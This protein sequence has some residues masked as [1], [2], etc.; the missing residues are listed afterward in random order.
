MYYHSDPSYP[1]DFVCYRLRLFDHTIR[2]EFRSANNE[3]R[4]EAAIFH[5]Q[6]RIWP[7]HEKAE[8]LDF[9]ET[10]FEFTLNK[11]HFITGTLRLWLSGSD[12]VRVF[13]EVFSRHGQVCNFKG[14][15][16]FLVFRKTPEPGPSPNP[17]PGP[18]PFPPIG[19]RH[20]PFEKIF[21]RNQA[22]TDLFQFAGL[23][24]PS[25]VPKE[26]RDRFLA[27]ATGSQFQDE[28][29]SLK[30][31]PDE[32]KE[33]AREYTGS[34]PF[35]RLNLFLSRHFFELIEL[36]DELKEEEEPCDHEAWIGKWMSWLC[37]GDDHENY[38]LWL[39]GGRDEA[40]DAYIALMVLVFGEDE[41]I[42]L[43]TK[44]TLWLRLL[45]FFIRS[46]E[47]RN[48]R[49]IRRSLEGVLILEQS[50]FISLITT[51]DEDEKGT[52]SPVGVTDLMVVRQRLQS[53]ELGEIA[54]IENVM[55]R[56][57]KTRSQRSKEQGEELYQLTDLRSN[58]RVEDQGE[59]RMHRQSQRIPVAIRETKEHNREKDI[60]RTFSNTD[61]KTSL[62]SN[63]AY[64]LVFQPEEGS[65]EQSLRYVQDQ[66]AVITQEKKESLAA[67]REIKLLR[68]WEDLEKNVVDNQDQPW[69]L[70]GVFR[71]VEQVKC[72]E[73]VRRGRHLL[74]EFNVP[75][76]GKGLATPP[77]LGQLPEGLEELLQEVKGFK[78][79]DREK[80][81]EFASAL[82]IT[83]LILP[84]ASERGLS[85]NL[86]EIPPFLLREVKLP[87][88]Y[89]ADSVQVAIVFDG[90]KVSGF[91]G[92]QVF[93][94]ETFQCGEA[95]SSGKDEEDMGSVV[96][97][98]AGLVGDFP[99][100]PSLRSESPQAC[101]QSVELPL[102]K[103]EDSLSIS[104]MTD[105]RNCN[106]VFMIKLKVSEEHFEVWQLQATSQLR[107]RVKTLESDPVQRK[108]LEKIRVAQ[109][110]TQLDT[111]QYRSLRILI[112]GLGI[113]QPF[114]YQYFNVPKVHEALNWDEVFYA[115][116][117]SGEGKGTPPLW[118]DS[119]D[120]DP[121]FNE[122][123]NADLA[124]VLVTIKNGFEANVL[125]SIWTN[126]KIWGG[127]ST[128]PPILSDQKFFANELLFD[129]GKEWGNEVLHHCWEDVEPT[130]MVY[131][132]EMSIV[133]CDHLYHPLPSVNRSVPYPEGRPQDQ[134]PEN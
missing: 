9:Q 90:T 86:S 79:L 97:R 31:D 7:D 53:Y 50:L 17:D 95:G 36:L 127:L 2:F 105:A 40:R 46:L 71:W 120:K 34:E 78:T 115:F 19:H 56:A 18:H 123:L 134:N 118:F 28:L 24:Q 126:G 84:P 91:A 131:L 94:Q 42:D 76:P 89:Q 102:N 66:Q 77:I 122:F 45:E 22:F 47:N 113:S 1:T 82:G 68:A 55:A 125:Y 62:K 3:Q 101:I 30:D 111:L 15:M 109:R 88:G 121:H 108:E 48:E 4:I 44:V 124:K 21:L 5:N 14:F 8:E 54:H 27:T 11:V 51:Q 59:N 39:R 60:E 133:G 87:A 32:M 80:Y 25:Q 75:F 52:V 65:L 16:A 128:D 64:S 49:S 35:T 70:H 116:R 110:K 67:Y 73:L 98:E 69:P 41:Q 43:M 119:N 10:P 38:L 23:H 37:P 57:K 61:E 74:L 114:F 33:V 72:S 13:A 129:N 99:P 6:K 63:G 107:A 92:K 85:V 106:A 103:E 96:I 132:D 93:D 104:L 29:R 83:E 130:D 112:E 81:L 26:D 100:I 20:E 58:G 12:S 117:V